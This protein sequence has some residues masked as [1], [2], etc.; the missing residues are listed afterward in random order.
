MN[1]DFI[2][3]GY[4]Y[5]FKCGKI[6]KKLVEQLDEINNKKMEKNM[7]WKIGKN[8]YKGYNIYSMK[9]YVDKKRI[10]FI[11]LTAI[12]II[13]T[14]LLI[15]YYTINTIIILKNV[16]SQNEQLINLSNQFKEQEQ[17]RQKKTQIYQENKEQI[18]HI[19]S[20]ET[21]R[22]FLT[23][24]D[25][26]SENTGSIINTLENYNIKANF[27]V[28]GSRVEAMP[29]KVKE[30]YEK[31]HFIGNHGYSHVYEAI[32]ASPQSVLDEYNKTNEAIKKAIGNN[33]FNTKLFRFPGGLVGGKYAE[34]KNQ[35]KQLLEENQI[36][37]VDWNALTGDSESTNP[38]LEKLMK[39]LKRTANGKN[40]VILLMHD[41]S[42]KKI[43]ADTLPQVIEYL[44]EQ[45]Y[46][47]KTFN[48]IIK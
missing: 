39:N 31:G 36:L 9:K 30:L 48:E 11:I 5:L 22:V 14:L 4:I 40:S 37:N 20:S 6:E 8:K 29:E 28:L 1:D 7:K 25:G 41:S 24:D 18:D 47:F 35:A 34:I 44:K 38:T 26:P 19:Y 43:T 17:Q 27:F 21:K 10:T 42:A 16:E 13:L 3:K 15:G 2:E 12:L 33:E 23:F 46:E 45:G 32:Y